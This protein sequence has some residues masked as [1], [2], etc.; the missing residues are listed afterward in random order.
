M[1]KF[2]LL[3]VCFVLF[4]VSSVLAEVTVSITGGIRT[5]GDASYA[6]TPDVKLP[7]DSEYQIA[8]D[9]KDNTRRALVKIR[10]DGRSVTKDGLILRAGE[11]VNLE[12]FL[13]SG[14]LSKGK[15]F[16]FIPKDEENLRADNSEDGYVI[17]S[18]QYEKSKEP[19][20]RYQDAYASSG[21]ATLPS[22]RYGYYDLSTFANTS[23]M[24]TSNI[25]KATISAS[26]ISDPFGITTEGSESIQR[27][28]RD[29]IEKMEDQ[30]DTLTIRLI[31]YYKTLPILLNR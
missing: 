20:V 14:T 22:N 26:S 10:I 31:G 23:S 12:R 28:Q 25:P 16:K 30:I 6:R 3:T 4:T 13:D 8:L 1:K 19:I 11:T 15:K 5:T 9:N 7:F 24:T 21:I 27:F 2:F 17:V 18:V 29:E